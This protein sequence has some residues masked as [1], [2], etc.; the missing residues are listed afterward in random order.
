MWLW[1]NNE[2]KELIVAFRGTEQTQWKDLLTDVRV[3]PTS[4]NEEGVKDIHLL[5]NKNEVTVHSKN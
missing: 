5:A 4:I 1:W 2:A 3:L